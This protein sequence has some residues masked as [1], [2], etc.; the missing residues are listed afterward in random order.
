MDLVH[1]VHIYYLYDVRYKTSRF[2]NKFTYFHKDEIPSSD[3]YSNDED[4]R[5]FEYRY[6]NKSL[7]D[8]NYKKLLRAICNQDFNGL[9]PNVNQSQNYSSFYFIDRNN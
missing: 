1:L 2:K 3:F 4:I 7:K 5:E 8:F 6:K 9:V